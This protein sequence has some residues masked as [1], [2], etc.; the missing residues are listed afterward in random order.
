MEDRHCS[1]P[2][3]IKTSSDSYT[4]LLGVFDGHGGDICA[5]FVSQHIHNEIGAEIQRESTNKPIKQVISDPTVLA[6]AFHNTD[7]A[8]KQSI[9]NPNK[10]EGEKLLMDKSGSTGCV[11]LINVENN[12]TTI[13]C[14]NAGDSRCVIFDA[15]LIPMSSDHKP[16]KTK[17]KQRIQGKNQHYE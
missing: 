5:D 8:F 12:V 17:E 4:S 16:F 13:T 11:S 10:S 3:L 14:A 9:S 6:N 2:E 1:V 15:T 7:E